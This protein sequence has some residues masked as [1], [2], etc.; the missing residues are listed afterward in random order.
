MGNR[1]R[2][3]PPYSPPIFTDTKLALLD[4]RAVLALIG[5]FGFTIALLA[6]FDRRGELPLL[7]ADQIFAAVRQIVDRIFSS[8][9]HIGCAFDAGLVIIAG[10]FADLAAGVP[11]V[12]EPL[13]R[14]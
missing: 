5:F 2:F 4:R 1:P 9:G 7:T 10:A 6:G 14:R 3:P 13:A 11:G 8:R 12:I